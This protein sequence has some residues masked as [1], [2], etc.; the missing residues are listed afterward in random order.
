VSTGSAP[1]RAAE[2]V[3]RRGRFFERETIRETLRVAH[4]TSSSRHEPTNP[5][6]TSLSKRTHAPRLDRVRASLV[7]R[8][9]RL[10]FFLFVVAFRH[11]FRLSVRSSD[12]GQEL[13]GDRV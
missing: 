10:F 4:G 1:F 2:G 5:S 11:S 13:R 12:G 6:L 9:F 7:A 8:R 3:A